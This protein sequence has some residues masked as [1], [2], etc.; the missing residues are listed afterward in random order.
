M[1]KSAETI[2][3]ASS[4][5]KSS[6][7]FFDKKGNGFMSAP[8][9]SSSFFGSYNSPPLIQRKLSIGQPN[10][11]YEQEADAVADKVVQRRVKNSDIADYKVPS[12]TSLVQLKCAECEKEE[13]LQKKED[14]QD[15]DNLLQSMADGRP[16]PVIQAKPVFETAEEGKLQRKCAAC[17]AEEKIQTKSVSEGAA[18]ISPSIESSLASSAGT[19]NTLPDEVK[20]NMEES[21]GADFSHVKVHT[22]STAVQMSDA[23]NAQAFAHG[24]DIYFN[25]GK[26]DPASKAGQH[27]LAHELTHTVQQNDNLRR[28]TIPDIQRQDFIDVELVGPV[29]SYTIPQTGQVIHVGEAAGARILL[30]IVL[31]FGGTVTLSWYNFALNLSESGDIR[32]WLMYQ[33]YSGFFINQAS[34]NILSS[35]LTAAQWRSLG[36]DP[37][38]RLLAL[39]EARTISIPDEVLLSSYKGMIYVEAKATLDRNEASI[40]ELLDA[41]DRVQRIQ[42]YADGLKEASQ[43]RDS[44]LAKKSE[45]ERIIAPRIAEL[46]HSLTQAHS[47]T[48]GFAG[49]FQNMDTLHR[50]QLLREEEQLRAPV[51]RIEQALTFWYEAFP[52]LTRLETNEINTV[53]VESKLRE[54]K[55]NIISTRPRL[56]DALQDR[57]SI[58]LMELL[59][60][61][62]SISTR[63][64]RRASATIQAED[65]RRGRNALIE[66]GALFA[67]GILLLFIP[68]GVFIDAA[69]GVA[70]AVK[71]ISDAMVFGRAANTGLHVD[72]GLMTQGQAR[73]AEFNAVLSTVFAVIGAAAAGFRVLRVGLA[74]SR[75]SSAAP[76]LTAAS[77]MG[78][79][80]VMVQH[81]ELLTTFRRTTQELEQELSRLNIRLTFEEIQGLRAAMFRFNRI[82]LVSTSRESLEAFLRRVWEARGTINHEDQV[83]NLY[84]AA[85]EANP[86][87]LTN[88]QYLEEIQRIIRSRPAGAISTLQGRS[89]TGFQRFLR[90]GLTDADILQLARADRV[91][92]RIYLNTGA[93]HAPEVMGFVVREIVD[94]PGRFPGVV[95]AKITGPG[96]VVRRADA[97][98]IYCETP[99]ASQ[100][101]LQ[102]ITEYQ[103]LNPTFFQ[104]TVPPMTNQVAEG[105]GIASEPL[106]VAGAESFGG[107]RAG[108]IFEA[109]QAVRARGGTQQEFMD[110]VF[111]VLRQHGFNPDA[112]HLNLTPAPATG[113]P[114]TSG[115]QPKLEL[116]K[117]D[118]PLE[119]EADSVADH[120]IDNL[121]DTTA[122][123]SKTIGKVKPSQNSV[124]AINKKSYLP[125][126]HAAENVEKNLKDSE[127][128]GAPMDFELRSKMENSFGADFSGIR[129]H[130][131]SIAQQT[132]KDLEAQAFAVGN[133]IYFNKGKYNPGSKDGQHLLAHE[134][135]HT[136]Q[137]GSSSQIQRTP[138]DKHDLTSTSLAGDPILES[139]FDNEAVIGR[140]ANSN[141][142]HV[143]R[144]QQALISLEIEL[145]K[146]GADEKYGSETEAGVKQFQ[147]KAGMSPNEWDGIVG[148]KTI[149]LLDRS[150]R[151]GIIST[152]TDKAQ[153]DLKVDSP[154][155]EADDEACKGKATDN[156]CPDPNLTVIKAADDAIKLIEKV[157]DEQLPPVKNKKADYPEIFTRIFRNGDTRDIS[158][159]VDEVRKNYEDIRK[160]LERIKKEKDLVRCATECDGG[161]RSGSPAYHTAPGGKH[162]ITFCPDF[163]K[164]EK[165]ILIVLH[166]CHHAAI[167]G[168]S[169]KAYAD[170]RLID[171]LDHNQALLNA[172]SF[173]V[174]AA[175]V[176]KPGSESIGPDIKDTNLIADKAQKDKTDL[177]LAFMEQWFRLV[178]F[179]ISETIQGAQE[180]KDK[181]H[182]TR[183]N[184]KVF[185][186]LVFSKWFGMNRPPLTPTELDIKKLKAIEDR[187][188]KMEKSFS[189][190]FVIIETANQSFWTDGPG[191]DIALNKNVLSLD[192]QHLV[193][194]L[195]Q[196]LVHATPN[197]SAESE[198]LYVGAIND[199]RSLRNLDP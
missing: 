188:E 21:I 131:D 76:E 108:S 73:M 172:A 23:L 48:F 146:F 159:K 71:S 17:D 4:P 12:Y 43:V 153:D 171:K 96:G 88:A 40:N 33:Y 165:R 15:A 87:N 175:W 20:S 156:P 35:Q 61:R 154:K 112:P 129:L 59:P 137:Q 199:V 94:N 158:F 64:G 191:N 9:V 184:P 51:R 124:N 105:I 110:E 10:D 54:I 180:A 28:K 14:G 185:M 118:D 130:T 162:I 102:R 150:L 111:N 1:G 99:G 170:T 42:D 181:G 120:V 49:N 52:L 37:L 186:E 45:T 193:I 36:S 126:N 83:Y 97:I 103:R 178:T 89:A 85:T 80:R 95:M 109:L 74:F 8:E 75:I 145:P 53:S 192:M 134:L 16:M 194:A 173:H 195:L 22:D 92:E 65:D 24:S 18:T 3:V 93:S 84:S 139:T 68:G 161:C 5:A 116:G 114:P 101:V 117:N 91:A 47:F 190:P 198:P 163:E 90:P 55:S 128:K 2:P 31:G 32:T 149:G 29:D 30:N 70:I 113:A 106:G 196:E 58:N 125:V 177:A 66:G 26:Y 179:D 46:E 151:N 6:Q 132:S 86:L 41:S 121:E 67:V 133:N 77:K 174:Y 63:I 82:P 183:N 81:P 98:V 62:E 127:G 142:T 148:R 11:K 147:Q 157:M 123:R 168:S 25:S 144:I 56:D 164:D 155:K 119:I 136:I 197:I 7:P 78:L 152:D 39:H 135:T 44:L 60:V 189:S 176:E 107:T 38:A 166:E 122:G 34:F 27:L 100:S 115:V 57:G 182:Y 143:K 19:G 50:L 79:A 138:D 69:I 169:D 104:H 13:K 141:G 167:S 187:T 72:D 160:F 140:F